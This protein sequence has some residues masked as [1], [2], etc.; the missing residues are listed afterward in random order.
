MQTA[1]CFADAGWS[2]INLSRTASP[3]RRVDNIQVDL[4]H[5]ASVIKAKA[6]L[7]ERISENQII[8]LVHNAAYCNKDS[9][10]SVSASQLEQAHQVNVVSPFLLGQSLIPKMGPGS[11]VLFIGST[12]AEKGV[13][14]AASYVVSK[15][16]VVGM[17][18]ATCQ[19]LAGTSIHT[20]CICPGFTDT[21]LLESHLSSQYS[22]AIEISC[23]GRMIHPREIAEFVLFAAGAPVLNG[24]VL[25]ASLGQIE[26]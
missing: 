20:A 5:Q 18:R 23:F 9:V 26:R 19:D 17:M 22:K 25:H 15:H 1:S 8:S 7:D 2:V 24:A 4:S 12:L 11:S 3:D 10:I 6:A 21:D 14:D 13:R 16:A